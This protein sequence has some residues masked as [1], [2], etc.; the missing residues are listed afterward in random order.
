MKITRSMRREYDR[1]DAI[2]IKTRNHRHKAK[3]QARRDTRIL[4]II[5]QSQLP[6][7]PHVMSWLSRKLNTPSSKITQAEVQSL[8]S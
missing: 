3:E 2:E 5:R 6:Y 1:L 4:T 7:A 8:L